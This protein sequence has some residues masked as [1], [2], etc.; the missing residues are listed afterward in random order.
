M[1]FSVS[2][3]VLSVHRTVAEPSVSMAAARR[4]STRAR[5]MRH[6]PI[7]MNTASTSGISS[8]IID[9]PMAMPPSAAFSHDPRRM[10]NRMTT[11]PAT[12]IPKDREIA[13]QP[14]KLRLQMRLFQRDRLQRLAD[15]AHF[16]IE[17]G[18][19]DFAPCRSRAQPAFRRR[20]RADRRRRVPPVLLLFQPRACARARIRR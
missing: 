1:R 6:A 13:H 4:V 8:G 20:R 11:S 3:P 17:A 9:M 10:P 19:G 5:E 2:V 16:G 15:L 12:A 18:R 7:A 14:A